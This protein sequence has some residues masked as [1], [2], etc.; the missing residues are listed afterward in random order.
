MFRTSSQTRAQGMGR[1]QRRGRTVSSEKSGITRLSD[2]RTKSSSLSRLP[3]LSKKLKAKNSRKQAQDVSSQPFT[4]LISAA[5]SK[6]GGEA[7]SRSRIR[8]A[9]FL[10]LQRRGR[11]GLALVGYCVAEGAGK[12][13][14]DEDQLQ[15]YEYHV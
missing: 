7:M 15:E 9:P 8:P 13:C 1:K 12:A 6:P 5:G 14:G 2:Q 10:C 3:R 4:R 11:G